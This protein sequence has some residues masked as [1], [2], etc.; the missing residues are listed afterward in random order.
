MQ[1]TRWV[2]SF[3]FCNT[4][5]GHRH[6]KSTCFLLQEYVRCL[7][8]ALCSTSPTRKNISWSL[9]STSS[10]TS[11]WVTWA[12]LCL[13]TL[14]RLLQA[15][16]TGTKLICWCMKVK[17]QNKEHH[18]RNGIFSA[19][20]KKDAVFKFRCHTSFNYYIGLQHKQGDHRYGVSCL[21]FFFSYTALTFP[22]IDLSTLSLHSSLPTPPTPVRSHA[23]GCMAK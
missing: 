9:Q 12:S 3:R 5:C 15:S 6:V 8:T 22:L 11:L 7:A 18:G 1:Q 23:G 13:S 16:P 19:K 21:S 20:M 2:K 14:W 10:S 4:Y 17:E